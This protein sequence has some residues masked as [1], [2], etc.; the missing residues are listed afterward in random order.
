MTKNELI[1]ALKE[2]GVEDSK[3]ALKKKT[4]DELK[5]MLD[6]LQSK[7][8]TAK[9]EEVTEEVAEEVVEEPKEEKEEQPREVGSEILAEMTHQLGIF[10]EF[11]YNVQNKGSAV[12]IENLG[13]G[14]VYTNGN[15]QANVGDKEQRITAGNKGVIYSDRISL[16]AASQPMVKITERG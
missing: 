8:E 13:G 16:I 1:D 15:G 3:T 9:E 14:D 4:N 6:G 10:T 12:V 5:A 2:L 7:E 11:I